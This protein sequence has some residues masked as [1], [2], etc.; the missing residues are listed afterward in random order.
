MIFSMLLSVNKQCHRRFFYSTAYCG[1]ARKIARSTAVPS[2][3]LT[4]W[5]EPL[6]LT[7]E[8][9]DEANLLF[10][11][12]VQF[13]KSIAHIDQAP[14]SNQPEVAFV[15]RSNVGKSTLINSL[16][17]NNRLVK[18]SSKPGHTKLLN[19]FE[20]GGQVTLVDMPGYGFKSKD[21]WGNLVVDY[22]TQ[23]QHLKRLFV[24]IDPT[25]GLKETD[26]NFI[27]YLDSVPL[28]YQIILT[29]R[30]RLAEP[31][32]QAS[33]AKI[34]DYLLNE[35]AICCF[36]ELLSCG[37]MKKDQEYNALLEAESTKIKH[38]IVQATHI[39]VKPRSTTTTRTSPKK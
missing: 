39:K 26:M 8:Q 20:I 13:I 32:F 19:F 37:K 3:Q 6:P 12:P 23:R 24:L 2:R 30:D 38:A 9:I 15:G 11:R 16:T 10:A 36:P 31:A 25:A 18:T 21:E 17:K 29:K 33:K 27:K 34:E 7:P 35:N 4:Q 5:P 22:L 28:S 1:L 14:E